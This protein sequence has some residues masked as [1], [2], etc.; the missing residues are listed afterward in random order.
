MFGWSA[1]R[2]CRARAPCARRA[3]RA[4]RPPRGSFSATRRSNQSVGAL[5]QPHRAHAACAQSRISRYGP[6]RSPLCAPTA[7][8]AAGRSGSWN[9][10]RAWDVRSAS[11][12]AE[13]VAQARL[14]APRARR[15]GRRATPA[16][17][18]GQIERVVEQ[19]V[20]CG[21][22]RRVDVELGPW[23]RLYFSASASQ[24]PRFLPV[25]PHGAIGHPQRLGDLLLGQPAEVAH[26]DHLG[27][28][29]VML[30]SSLERLVHAQ[31]L[32]LRPSR[33]RPPG[34]SA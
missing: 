9:L 11:D 24:Q 16:A 10:P 19:A 28:A 25:A 7:S 17:R 2:G 20:Q 8:S 18:R 5:G 26:L 27:H 6:T 32:V 34:W 15:E 4:A 3:R 31:N 13:E 23:R 12:A 33:R 1:Q 22:G 21:P 29:R 14:A 30:A